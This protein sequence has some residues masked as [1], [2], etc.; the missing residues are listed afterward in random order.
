MFPM[1]DI[2]P[3]GDFADIVSLGVIQ[4]LRNARGVGGYVSKPYEGVGV[5]TSALSNVIVLPNSGFH[6]NLAS[7]SNII[8]SSA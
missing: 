6:D 3:W 7:V 8:C 2:G 5:F 1:P 4:V